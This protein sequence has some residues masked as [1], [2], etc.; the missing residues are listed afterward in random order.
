MEAP[1]GL[2]EPQPDAQMKE[3]DGVQRSAKKPR[4]TKRS[5]ADT[6]ASHGTF[7]AADSPRLEDNEWAFE[8]PE[9]ESD[10][11]MEVHDKDDTRPRVK[12]SKELRL[13]LC[14]EW[15]LALIIR[16][17]GKNISFNILNQR[18]PAMWN[19]QGRFTLIDIGYGHFVARFENKTDYLHVLLDGPWKIFDNYLVTQR[20]VPEFRPRTAKLS[21]MAVWIRLP[22]LPMEYFRDDI[23]KSI[24]EDVG[25]PLKI[26]RTTATRVKGRFARAAVEVDLNKPLVSEVVV[27]NS[28]Q[29]IEYEGLHVVCFECGVVGHRDQDCPSKISKPPV[30]EAM[31]LN[32][33]P[34]MDKEEGQPPVAP[35]TAPSTVQERR[36]YGSWML[37]TRKP[38]NNNQQKTNRQGNQSGS[39]PAKNNNQFA[40]LV[41][42]PEEENANPVPT[43]KGKQQAYRGMN[44]D[45]GRGK[46]KKKAT[47]EP[48]HTSKG[49]SPTTPSPPQPIPTSTQT[50]PPAESTM[51]PQ[52]APQRARGRGGFVNSGRSNGRGSGRGL[53][54]G[55]SGSAPLMDW[56]GQACTNGLFQFGSTQVTTGAQTRSGP[57][58]PSMDPS[59]CSTSREDGVQTSLPAA[60]SS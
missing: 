24:L 5:F 54:A 4:A 23:I 46:T 18:L 55:S 22:E 47:K 58:P 9:I 50:N 14:R 59:I 2:A 53:S 37:V 42:D 29:P 40:A 57:P 19:L 27:L 56:C 25:K 43:G 21:K 49:K 51:N 35:T 36:P 11:E 15:K 20:W 3:T 12:I 33:T 28:A 45:S 10:S 31:D 32:T 17:S 41:N 60:C 44:K 52:N 30:T 39:K 38:K 26:D 6:V 13:E 7:T 48:G 8:D 16:Y 34:D 1:P